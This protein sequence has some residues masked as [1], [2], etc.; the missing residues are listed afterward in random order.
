[1]NEIRKLER[2]KV[3]YKQ[4]KTIKR[5]KGKGIYRQR[6]RE[7]TKTTTRSSQIQPGTD[8]RLPVRGTATPRGGTDTM[9]VVVSDRQRS[10]FL[11]FAN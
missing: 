6:K 11:N 10:D 1:M 9:G 5:D 2:N 3:R 8:P 4:K 7:T